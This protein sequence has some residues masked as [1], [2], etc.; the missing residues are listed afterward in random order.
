MLPVGLYKHSSHFYR[1]FIHTSEIYIGRLETYLKTSDSILL[2]PFQV[3]IDWAKIEAK[4]ESEFQK[5]RERPAPS[6]GGRR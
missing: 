2:I 5:E 6:T 4:I 1:P 3:E